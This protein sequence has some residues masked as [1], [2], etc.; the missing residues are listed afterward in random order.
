MAELI[1][2]ARPYAKAAFEYAIE[3]QAL[4]KW[5]EMLELAAAI[6]GN[7]EMQALIHNPSIGQSKLASVITEVGGKEFDQSLANFLK[8][9]AANMRLAVVVDVALLFQAMKSAYEKTVD[10]TVTAAS[11]LTADQEKSLI[12]ALEKR[13][14]TTVKLESQVDK[15]LLGGLIIQANDLVIDGSLRGKL[16]RLATNMLA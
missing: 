2:I 1:T 10:I 5:S 9:L 4:A 6:V 14:Q 3:K 11:Q 15:S 8:V 16:A 13:F 7:E 12:T